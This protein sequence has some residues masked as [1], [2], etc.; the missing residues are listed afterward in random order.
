MKTVIQEN[1][2]YKLHAEVTDIMAPENFKHIKFT[3]TFE[4]SR[5]PSEERR[6]FELTLSP[7]DYKHLVEFLSSQQS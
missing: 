7:G 3:S 6:V 5:I 1:R 2:A 4:G